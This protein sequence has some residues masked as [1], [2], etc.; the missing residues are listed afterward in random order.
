MKS[1]H[2][3]K[4]KEALQK[5]EQANNSFE[6]LDNIAGFRIEPVWPSNPPEDAGLTW[7]PAITTVFVERQSSNFAK[8]VES[9]KNEVE[10]ELKQSEK[11]LK[12]IGVK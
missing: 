2:L 12:E 7:P 10:E 6:Q 5:K 1:E 3:E 9:Y 4:A 8:V 11:T